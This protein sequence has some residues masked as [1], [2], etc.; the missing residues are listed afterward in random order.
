MNFILICLIIA[1]DQGVKYL[2]KL[3]FY[4][5]NSKV[6]IPGWFS[7]TYLENRGAAFG[8]FNGKKFIL[9]GIVSIVILAFIYYLFRNRNINRLTRASIILII[10]GAIGNLIDRI[11]YGYVID[12]FHFY[13]SDIFD[14]PV[15]NVADIAVVVG[16][17]LLAV[18]ILF[19]KKPE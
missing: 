14:W 6:L 16:T 12:M 13:I 9:I 2:S 7:F 3:Y 18:A 5:G 10:G 1:L 15:F 19:E 8:I 4:P 17:I 11:A